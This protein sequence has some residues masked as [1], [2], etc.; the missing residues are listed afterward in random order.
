[1]AD[2]LIGIDDTDNATSRGTGFLAR[3]LVEECRRRGGLDGIGG[4]TRH[5]LLADPRIPYTSHNSAACAALSGAAGVEPAGFVFDVVAA[6][7]APGSD[8][9]V[10]VARMEAVTPEVV[11]FGRRA[12]SQIVRMDEALR[13]ARDSGIDLRP[14][15]G[16]GL[17]VIGAL[18]AV[19][20]R[21]SGNDGRYID[22]PGLRDLPERV[23]LREFERLG[24][25]VE[26]RGGR[27]PVPDDVYETLGWV[28]PNLVGGRPVLSV[29]WS[30]ERHAWLPVERK[31]PRVVE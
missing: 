22:L 7:S 5:Q 10:C 17:G 26:H 28:R 25:A 20:L 18:A 31:R 12:R 11:E 29:T 30:E 19:G 1:M 8:P 24:I 16:T 13:L 27:A 21:A 3:T 4:V 6:R 14:L 2:V 23:S 9:G 15:S